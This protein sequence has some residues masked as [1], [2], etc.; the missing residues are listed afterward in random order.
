VRENLA[1]GLQL[2]KVPA[3][4][5][6]ERVGEIARL[7]QIDA[8]LGR[9]PGQLS[10]GQ[11]QRV[12]M[13]RAM[14]REPR[15]FLF[16]EPLSNLDAALRTEMRAELAALH[17]KNNT[18]SIYVTHDQVEAMTLGSRIAVLHDGIL[19]QVDTPLALYER[20][21]NQFVAGFIGTPCMNFV[22]GVVAGY[23]DGLSLRS[24][25]R[26]W[27]LP[28]ATW[29][30]L[31]VGERATLGVRPQRVGIGQ[32]G[33]RANV[34]LVEPMGWDAH[35]HC[36]LGDTAVVAQASAQAIVGLAPGDAVGLQI[37]PRDTFVFN[38]AGKTVA[39]AEVR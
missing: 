15:V 23:R 14:V 16:D 20:P 12:A 26:W 27:D 39:Y 21:V 1:F 22:P 33:L 4:R 5:I 34:E 9:K 10:G 19:Q 35:L 32:K 28:R 30:G 29:E 6:E 37:A 31:T 24:G 38:S 11:R 17:R 18:T 3:A 13:G 36:R 7:L 8:L 2:R 25:D